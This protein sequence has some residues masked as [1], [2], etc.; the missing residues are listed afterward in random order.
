M[1]CEQ[2]NNSWGILG[3]AMGCNK[4][5]KQRRHILRTWYIYKPESNIQNRT[6]LKSAT[7][8]RGRGTGRGYSISMHARSRMIIDQGGGSLKPSDPKM[9][10]YFFKW[11]S[12]I[13]GRV[14]TALRPAC[15]PFSDHFFHVR[16]RRKTA[17]LPATLEQ[18]G[19]EMLRWRTYFVRIAQR[20]TR[21]FLHVCM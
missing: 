14:I 2:Y 16:C 1:Y 11:L 5:T 19:G 20:T 13:Y 17:V 15:F 7:H 4:L 12:H 10:I 6:L 21:P 18:G 9:D 3:L 8:D